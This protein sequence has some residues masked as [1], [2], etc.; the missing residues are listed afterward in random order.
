MG[1]LLL[2]I[3]VTRELHQD[4]IKPPPTGL[5]EGFC[6]RTKKLLVSERY[7]RNILPPQM[8]AISFAQKQMCVVVKFAPL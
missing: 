1:K 3:S 2:E 8:K 4:L 6:K 7:L 5:A